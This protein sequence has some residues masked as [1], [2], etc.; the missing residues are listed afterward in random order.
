LGSF[1]GS[2]GSNLG[3]FVKKQVFFAFSVRLSTIIAR[4]RLLFM[5]GSP[6]S[7][8]LWWEAPR[9][10]VR[11]LSPDSLFAFTGLTVRFHRNTQAGADTVSAIAVVAA[12]R[13][14]DSAIRLSMC[15]D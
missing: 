9:V 13:F 10:S 7:L 2:L 5:A 6:D 11:S 12:S 1:S 15:R 3:S 4:A 14:F 8:S